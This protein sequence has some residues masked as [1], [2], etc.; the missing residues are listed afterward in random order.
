MHHF[1]NMTMSFVNRP[2]ATVANV[3]CRFDT[4]QPSARSLETRVLSFLDGKTNAEEL[5]HALYDHV[6]DEPLPQ[7]L[8][9]ILKQAQAR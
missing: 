2:M 7:S 9:T 5:L 3:R 4:S 1:G 6:L 8:R